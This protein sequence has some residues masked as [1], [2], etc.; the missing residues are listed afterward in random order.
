M[1]PTRFRRLTL[2]A[3]LA[4]WL[5]VA[6]GCAGSGA[7]AERPAFISHVVF[8][9]LADP[10]DYEEILADCERM[11]APIPGVAAFAAGAH[12]D[13]GRPAAL[14]DY[15]LGL[16]IGFDTEAHYASYVTHPDH[17]AVLEKWRPRLEWLRIYD[18]GDPTP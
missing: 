11:L 15:D 6:W 8:L 12:L 14:A 2:I 13:T 7:R 4:A 9:K 5:G 3:L 16:Y 1:D 17:V 10:T 18:I